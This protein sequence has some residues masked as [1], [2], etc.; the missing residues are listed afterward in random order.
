MN[1]PEELKYTK[2]HEWA[3]EEGNTV[4]VGITDHAQS[5][6][7]DIVFVELPEVGA[8]L[9]VGDSLG[10]V[11]SVKAVSDLYSPVSGKI[12]A[13]N[14]DLADNPSS[15]N[16]DPYGDAWIAKIEVSEKGDLMDA[17]SYKDFVDSLA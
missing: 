16:Q 8:E 5:S 12:V 6:L 13:I 14:E 9:S 4:V 10:V 1:F 17:Q 7:G 3:R 2:D 15:I 11:E